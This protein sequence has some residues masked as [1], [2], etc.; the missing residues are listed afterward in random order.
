MTFGS[1]PTSGRL[2]TLRSWA[3]AQQIGVIASA[4]YADDDDEAWFGFAGT[5]DGFDP[6]AL[7]EVG[8]AFGV[9]GF[10]EGEQDG[11]AS[12]GVLVFS[13]LGDVVTQCGFAGIVFFDLAFDIELHGA[14]GD[15]D[16]GSSACL[17]DD[18]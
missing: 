15:E 14:E 7:E 5:L 2:G 13:R 8:G 10:V 9:N 1:G 4:W 3:R 12:V 11:E 16:V 6:D 17:V 18:L